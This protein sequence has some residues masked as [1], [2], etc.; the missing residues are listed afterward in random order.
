MI[1]DGVISAE[2][3]AKLLEAL[4]DHAPPASSV[5]GSFPSVERT[6]PRR[7]ARWLHILVS[8]SGKRHVDLRLPVSLFGAGKKIGAR[9]SPGIDDLDL[10]SL[11]TLIESGTIGK[12]IDIHKEDGRHVEIYLE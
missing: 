1:Q 7:A 12:V 10:N 8:H 11:Q 6:A 4:G 2:Q 5:P 3:G 9:F